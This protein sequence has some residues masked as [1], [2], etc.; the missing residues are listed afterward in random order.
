MI[1]KMIDLTHPVIRHVLSL[2]PIQRQQPVHLK[3]LLEVLDAGIIERKSLT[4]GG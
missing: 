3:Q 2:K 4:P 1:S